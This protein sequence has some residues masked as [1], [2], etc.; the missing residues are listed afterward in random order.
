MKFIVSATAVFMTFFMVSIGTA[1]TAQ[2]EVKPLAEPKKL[3]S[4]AGLEYSDG[5]W[6]CQENKLMTCNDGRW[7]IRGDE[8]AAPCRKPDADDSK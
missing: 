1:Q 4:Y 5:S 2:E 6:H 8:C 7:L 3:C